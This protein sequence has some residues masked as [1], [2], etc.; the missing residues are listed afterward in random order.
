MADIT[1][2][3]T[4]VGS[5]TLI[6][7]KPGEL[8]EYSLSGVFSA[9]A[10][11]ERSYGS[12]FEIV[13]THTATVT[14]TILNDKQVDQQYRW[15]VSTYVSGTV[16]A[17]LTDLP[18]V[19]QSFPNFQG[20]KNVDI[21]EGGLSLFASAKPPTEAG[22]GRKYTKTVNGVVEEFY[23]DSSGNE[24]QVTNAGA[25]AGGTATQTVSPGTNL[26]Q[27]KIGLIPSTGGKV[28]LRAGTHT[29]TTGLTLK[30]HLT[31]E[32]EGIGNTI[33]DLGSNAIR[34]F[35]FPATPLNI[36]LRG[37]TIK[38][39]GVTDLQGGCEIQNGGGERIKFEDVEFDD[40]DSMITGNHG[41]GISFFIDMENVHFRRPSL[42]TSSIFKQAP[43]SA[44]NGV[45]INGINCKFDID[46]ASAQFSEWGSTNL[47]NF[48]QTRMTGFSNNNFNGGVG[49]LWVSCR[50][51]EMR[52]AANG[53]VMNG[54]TFAE[55][56]SISGAYNRFSFCDF[57]AGT[58]DIGG[59]DTYLFA[60]TGS[61]VIF[62]AGTAAGSGD[63]TKIYG[64]AYSGCRFLDFQ[65]ANN[66]KDWIINGSTIALATDWAV[67]LKGL[68]SS[69]VNCR[70]NSNT[71]G[72]IRVNSGAAGV[73]LNNN[74]RF[75]NVAAVISVAA[76]VSDVSIDGKL[77]NEVQTTDATV[78]TVLTIPVASGEEVKLLA[79]TVG[80]QTS[81]GDTASL[82]NAAAFKN[83][84]G[85]LTQVG[86]TQVLHVAMA[87]A[88]AALWTQTFSVSGTDVLVR[89]TGEAAKTIDWE[90]KVE[91]QRQLL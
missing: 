22:A 21:Y 41:G 40:L 28:A 24:V 38:G 14:R 2:N 37:M 9:T 34:A 33:L 32:G 79:H 77:T 13:E 59:T 64:G 44:I 45:E 30:S 50:V 47:F 54:G 6:L 18:D 66:S 31:I 86:T 61:S 25:V 78:T 62:Q 70:F 42:A 80:H 15:R 72:D 68:G 35:L 89:V 73:V 69:V 52:L 58:Y 71:N 5:T 88:G 83:I 55:S 84:A 3:F 7:V 48:S 26:I 65:G 76:G 82:G 29:M 27:A 36:T 46:I 16:T 20:Q 60:C 12:G 43:A 11:L 57:S 67:D 85:T 51:T 1:Q 87:N 23:L 10:V 90:V 91:R 56:F 17:A 53:H 75:E 39:S 63:R 4:A 81:T 49:S 19:V 74:K 8:M